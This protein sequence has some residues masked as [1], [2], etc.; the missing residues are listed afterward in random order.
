MTLWHSQGTP[1]V[2][3][4]APSYWA[5]VAA[6]VGNSLLVPKIGA[7]R[8]APQYIPP[9]AQPAINFGAQGVTSGLADG[10]SGQ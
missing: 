1:P 8:G 2:P 3:H 5:N 9:S 6:L 7:R 4:D 10:P